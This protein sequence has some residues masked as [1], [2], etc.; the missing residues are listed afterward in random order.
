MDGSDS[1]VIWS[2]YGGI[3][4]LSDGSIINFQAVNSSGAQIYVDINGFKG[5]NVWGKDIFYIVV[6]YKAGSVGFG[7]NGVSRAYLLENH[8]ATCNKSP[9]IYKGDYCGALIQMDGWTIADDY[10]W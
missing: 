3:I 6:S 8:N 1:N 4:I 9:G 2:S 5:P 10:P 7:V